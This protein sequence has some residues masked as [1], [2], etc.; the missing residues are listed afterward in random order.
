VRGSGERERG[1]EY[2]GRHGEEYGGADGE[3]EKGQGACRSLVE[4]IHGFMN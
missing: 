1:Q 4:T 3:R 2:K